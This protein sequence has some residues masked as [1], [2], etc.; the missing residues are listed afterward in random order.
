MLA[1]PYSHEAGPTRQGWATLSVL[2]AW[3]LV[4]VV[5]SLADA[6][7][8]RAARR[9]CE[10]AALDVAQKSSHGG[11]GQGWPGCPLDRYAGVAADLQAE[12]GTAGRAD[13]VEARVRERAAR[14]RALLA[15]RL[16]VR[17]GHQP[18]R[19]SGL[20]LLTASLLFDG[21]LSL[22]AGLVTLLLLGPLIERRRGRWALLALLAGGGA[23]GAL[24]F[25]V[26]LH[27]AGGTAFSAASSSLAALLGA[28]L[29][30]SPRGRVRI[31]W[32]W[33]WFR[34]GTVSAPAACVVPL[35]WLLCL[36]W[37]GSP[38]S[39]ARVL[40]L[41]A[42]PLALGVLV[43]L[44]LQVGARARSAR[45]ALPPPRRLWSA[46][47]RPA[48]RGRRVRTPDPNRPIRTPPP[49][50]GGQPRMMLR[51]AGLR[52]LRDDRAIVTVGPAVVEILW[53]DVRW[54]AAG[55][56]AD[57][58]PMLD[59]VASLHD[60]PT[61]ITAKGH[62]IL[63]SETDFGTLFHVP[64]AAGAEEGFALLVAAV[65][66]LAPGALPLPEPTALTEPPRYASEASHD[67]AVQAA[68]ARSVSESPSGSRG[69]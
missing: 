20:S 11:V 21:S 46:P 45:S 7:S 13:A 66:S 58:G 15:A 54:V 9:M 40:L 28:G 35:V 43:E 19:P 36:P 49:S 31:V 26:W 2:A 18:D 32:S 23:A 48:R 44:G 25:D 68:L 56:A 22:L 27:T 60:T 39:P 12:V 29:V 47:R 65:C 59:L 55:V 42:V 8:G 41:H 57:T 34:S 53:D 24:A 1:L 6:P 37:S 64:S 5:V 38:V 61:G 16:R 14:A 63:A 30:S 51:R 67:A 3:L 50:A 69:T 4:H 10:R 33:W 62:R 52:G 17:L